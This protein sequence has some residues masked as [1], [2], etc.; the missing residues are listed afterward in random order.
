VA[1]NGDDDAGE[2]V[3]RAKG[4]VPVAAGIRGCGACWVLRLRLE[5]C[6]VGVEKGWFEGAG[7]DFAKG[8]VDC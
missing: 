2:A 1:E 7:E 4:L 5:N 6:E 3:A 8:L